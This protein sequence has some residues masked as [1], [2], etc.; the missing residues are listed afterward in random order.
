MT[1]LHHQ[2]ALY[3]S[4]QSG[5]V[6]SVED[7]P[8]QDLFNSRCLVLRHR[9]PVARRPKVS[10]QHKEMAETMIRALIVI[11]ISTIVVAF[12]P[13]A[14]GADLPPA[15]QR[16]VLVISVDGL[17]P[18]L[19]LRADTPRIHELL[20]QGSFTFWAETT[21]VSLTLPSH[22]SMMTGVPPQFHQIE[23]NRDIEFAQ[24]VYPSVPTLFEI[25]HKAGFSTAMVAGKSKFAIMNKPGTIDYVVVP[26]VGKTFGNLDVADKTIALINEFQPQVMLMHVPDVDSA[27]HALGWSSPEQLAAIATADQAIGKVLDALKAKGILDQTLVI[28]SAD[29]GGAGRNHGAEDARSRH[30]P[31]I[32]IGP[33]VRKGYDLTIQAELKVKT[34]DTCATSLDFLGIPVPT[35]MT[36][37]PVTAIYDPAGKELLAPVAPQPTPTQ[38]PATQP[39]APVGAATKN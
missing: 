33:G 8:P 7:R 34:E 25:A 16:R 39:A 23:W 15:P 2:W 18:D 38:Q 26:A 20:K 35:Y 36:G 3:S 12:S 11:L 29:H 9:A 27:G 28:I 19:A 10:G 4:D 6:V 17:R 14:Q 22:V 31:W 30:I 21:V 13:S 1:G 5:R 24:P 32:V 37:K